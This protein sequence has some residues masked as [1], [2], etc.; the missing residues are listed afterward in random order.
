MSIKAPRRAG[1][2]GTYHAGGAVNPWRRS[3]VRVTCES[4]VFA[5]TPH[6]RKPTPSC[7]EI[8]SKRFRYF[9]SNRPQAA[10]SRFAG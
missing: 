5:P 6:V 2:T 3:A 1:T 4:A 7:R 10:C 9:R 8:S